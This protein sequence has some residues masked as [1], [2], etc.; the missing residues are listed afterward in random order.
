MRTRFRT[1]TGDRST[2]SKELEVVIIFLG[3]GKTLRNQSRFGVGAVALALVVCCSGCGGGDSEGRDSRSSMQ[4]AQR[5]GAEDRSQNE[6]PRIEALHFEPAA[7]R[8]GDR[9]RAVVDASDA[10]DDRLTYTFLW[11][12][13]GIQ[14]AQQDNTIKLSEVR[15]GQSIAVTVTV[16]DGRATSE[17]VKATTRVRNRPPQLS[18]VQLESSTPISAGVDVT[19]R[20]TARDL[21]GDTLT[22]RYVWWVNGRST[23]RS[24]P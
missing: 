2:S 16:H 20:P 5:I 8:I 10:D 1:C 22:Y 6:I 11:T 23:V 17:A 21:D 9:L 18:G 3:R 13:N 14:L 24:G 7:P 4:P 12:L 19:A 15:K